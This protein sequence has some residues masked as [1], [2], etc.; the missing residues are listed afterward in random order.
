MRDTVFISAM[1]FIFNIRP[2]SAEIQLGAP[3][4]ELSAKPTEGFPQSKSFLTLIFIPSV[5]QATPPLATRGGLKR[6]VNFLIIL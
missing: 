2:K 4:G 5:A 1:L 6:N 3:V